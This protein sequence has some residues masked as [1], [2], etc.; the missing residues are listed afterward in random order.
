[1]GRLGIAAALGQAAWAAARQWRS[2]PS[3]RRER[4][5]VLLR[6][7]GG[8]PSGLSAAERQELRGIVGELHLGDVL[9]E[10][11]MRASG[12]RTRTRKLS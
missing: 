7:S 10:S 1:M 12:I 4:L 6:R 3:H 9:R 11:A 5:Q 8:R 2:L